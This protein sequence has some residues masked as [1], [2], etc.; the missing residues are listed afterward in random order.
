MEGPNVSNKFKGWFE[1]YTPTTWWKLGDTSI[2]V[3]LLGGK[4]PTPAVDWKKAAEDYKKAL[5][6]IRAFA[7]ANPGCGFSCGKMAEKAL[8]V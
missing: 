8:L 5:E 3:R 7:A 6:E 1:A 2:P 4:A